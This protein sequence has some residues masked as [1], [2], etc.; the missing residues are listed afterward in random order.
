[1]ITLAF[2]FGMLLQEGGLEILE[3]ETLY[4]EGWLFTLSESYRQKG[5]IFQGDDRKHDPLDQ[6]RIDHRVT[7]TV[8][9]GILPELTLTALVPWVDRE[10]DEEYYERS[11]I[12]NHF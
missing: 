10:L 4:Q 9:Y 11:Q 6:L 12:E 7:A 3:G 5:S 2:A 8:N 1:M